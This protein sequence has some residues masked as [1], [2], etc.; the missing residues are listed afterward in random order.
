MVVNS[1]KTEAMYFSKH[2]QVGLKILVATSEIQVLTTMRVLGVM[3][4]SKLSWGESHNIVKKKIRALRKISTDFNPSELLS[5]CHGS[6]HSVLYYAADTWL[7]EVLQEKH[8]RRLK[9]LSNST[10]QIVFLKLDS[11]YFQTMH[12]MFSLKTIL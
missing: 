8:P 4:D 10:L 7:N 11:Q 9:V 12:M 6:I 2:D 1:L 5:N 3:F